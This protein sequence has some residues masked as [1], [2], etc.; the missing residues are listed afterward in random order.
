MRWYPDRIRASRPV[1]GPA[2]REIE[3]LAGE[4]FRAIGMA[5][6]ADDEP[7]SEDTLATYAIDGR[8]WVAVDGTGGGGKPVAYVL[9]DAVDGNA[10]VAQ[11][12]VLPEAQGQGVGRALLEQVRAWAVRSGYRGI[13]LTTFSGVPWNRPLYE[14]LGFVVLAPEVVGPELQAVVERESD[15]GHH[16]APRVCMGVGTSVPMV[17]ER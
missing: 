1:D 11:L 4:A 9:V 13:T 8:S 7:P 2:L 12:S 10:H 16:H 17:V 3:R 15:C 14:H 5:T 6:I